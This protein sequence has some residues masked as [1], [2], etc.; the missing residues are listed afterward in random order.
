VVILLIISKETSDRERLSAHAEVIALQERLGLSYKD[1]CHRLYMA[2]V[3]K[4]KADVKASKA[5][6]KLRETTKKALE[7]ALDSFNVVDAKTS[8]KDNI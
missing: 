1:A 4:V 2:E 3:E 5:F 8:D 7:K 6:A